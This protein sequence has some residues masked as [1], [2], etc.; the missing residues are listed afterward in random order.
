MDVLLLTSAYLNIRNDRPSKYYSTPLDDFLCKLYEGEPT[1]PV[2]VFTNVYQPN[3]TIVNNNLK[4]IN[5]EPDMLLKEFWD[6]AD[7]KD[8]YQKLNRLSELDKIFETNSLNLLAIWLGKLA[9]I[10]K[11]FEAGYETVL[12]FDSGH[13]TSHQHFADFS[14]YSQSMLDNVSCYGLK[15]RVLSASRTYG[16]ILTQAWSTLK[17]LHIP[18]EAYY[19]LGRE[20]G[21]PFPEKLP[22]YQAVFMLIHKSQFS[23][24]FKGCQKWWQKLIN[25]GYGG[26]EESAITLYGWENR[27]NRIPYPNWLKVLYGEEIKEELLDDYSW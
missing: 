20:M 18:F 16:I 5:L 24:F 8:K 3:K 23:S 14:K 19:D 9:M 7:W 15:Q 2:W 27:I 17:D 13:W 26:T 22:L 21:Y 12:W 10:K 4:I 25:N 11:G 6:V 1:F